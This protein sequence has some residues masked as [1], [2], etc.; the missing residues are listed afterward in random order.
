M[1]RRPLYAIAMALLGLYGATQPAFA[2]T[3]RDDVML[4]TA[5]VAI[6]LMS[7]YTFLYAVKWYFGWDAKAPPPSEDD[8]AH[9]ASGHDDHSDAGHGAPAAAHH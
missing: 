3:D 2:A 4:G 7:L 6:G 8:H 5:A 1:L 9:G